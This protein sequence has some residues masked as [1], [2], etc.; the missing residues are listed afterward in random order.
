MAE[1]KSGK[2]RAEREAAS[3]A[4]EAG[5]L[6]REAEGGGLVTRA[7]GIAVG[8]LPSLEALH[9]AEHDRAESARQLASAQALHDRS[10]RQ[11][12]LERRDLEVRLGS[13]FTILS[14]NNL[15]Q[16]DRSLLPST[17]LPWFNGC[18]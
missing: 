17:V 12:D 2:A 6:R 11:W 8:G 14:E 4:A 9:R 3:A 18:L 13:R 16:H 5:A 7:R 10:A 15:V 1:L